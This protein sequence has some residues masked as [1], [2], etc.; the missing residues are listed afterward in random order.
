MVTAGAVVVAYKNTT[1]AYG[2]QGA[3]DKVVSALPHTTPLRDDPEFVNQT[4]TQN[5]DR[6]KNHYT[7]FAS[8]IKAVNT[9]DPAAISIQFFGDMMLDRNVAK[10]MGDKGLDYLFERLAGEDKGLYHHADLLIANLEGAFAPARVPTTKS[11]AFRFD[12]KLAADIKRYQFDAVSSANNHS[13]DMGWANVDF[14]KKTLRE[15][16]IGWF[17]TQ[18]KE[19]KDLTWVAEIPGKIDKVAFIGLNNTDHPLDMPKVTE[20]IKDAKEKARYVIVFMH[21]GVEYK[22]ISRQQERDLAHRLIDNGVTAVIGAHPHV[23]QEMELYEGKP[24]FYSLGNFIFDQYFSTDTQQGLSV[25]MI[26]ENGAAKT[27]YA[28]PLQGEKS[29]V[30]LM[31]P[32]KRDEFLD[33]FNTNSRLGDN[34]F[35]QGK[36]EL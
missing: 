10:M 5:Q 32:A 1:E 28:F 17:G 13:L 24:I 34:K 6:N 27:V 31:E 20:A 23:I 7:N 19:S 36:L 16:G 4:T 35:V 30:E 29:Q 18:T 14:T 15:N 9:A 3:R 12:P 21:W 2:T 11:I 25:G 8:D 33:W 22:R 26:L